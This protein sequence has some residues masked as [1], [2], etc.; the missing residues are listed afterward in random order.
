MLPAVF[1]TRG[2]DYLTLFRGLAERAKGT[3][4][5]SVSDLGK[6]GLK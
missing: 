3:Q 2:S 4:I 6:S 5:H 1:G